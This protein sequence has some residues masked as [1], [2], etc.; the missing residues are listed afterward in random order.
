MA[1]SCSR[2]PWRSSCLV[3]ISPAAYPRA[4]AHRTPRRIPTGSKAAA[5]WHRSGRG[6][7]PQRQDAAL[8]GG[9]DR[10]GAALHAELV[11]DVADVGLHRVL[12][13]AKLVGDS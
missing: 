5:P 10:L 6:F 12:G 13:E 4:S 8:Q 1:P 2:S 3:A 7:S 11:E 9:G